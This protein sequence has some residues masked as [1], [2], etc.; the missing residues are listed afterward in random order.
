MLAG[1]LSTLDGDRLGSIG[2]QLYNAKILRTTGAR[3]FGSIGKSIGFERIDS[4]LAE[5]RLT[6]VAGG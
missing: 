5:L 1:T 4:A 2:Q 3:S 6:S